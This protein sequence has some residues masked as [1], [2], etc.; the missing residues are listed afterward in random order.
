MDSYARGA[1]GAP[2]ARPPPRARAR[3]PMACSVLL[4]AAA[5]LGVIA[6]KAP[7]RAGL[8]LKSLVDPLGAALEAAFPTP[9]KGKPP[10]LIGFYAEQSMEAKRMKYLGGLLEQELPGTKIIWL[11]A[12]NNPMNERLR[13]TIDIRGQ[14]GGV[15][16]L[17]NRKTGKVLCGVVAYDKLRSWAQGLGGDARIYREMGGGGN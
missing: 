11:E 13:A 8:G 14:C 17:F 9:E 5:L 3:S 12:W 15:P 1:G 16:Y 6:S 7:S 10:H 2:A 4:A